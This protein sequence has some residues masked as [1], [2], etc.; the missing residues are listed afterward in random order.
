MCNSLLTCS[1]DIFVHSLVTI[2]PVFSSVKNIK[3]LRSYLGCSLHLNEQRLIECIETVG[4]CLDSEGPWPCHIQI[5]LCC[6]VSLPRVFH[7][8]LLRD[9]LHISHFGT[10]QNL[11]FL[12]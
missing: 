7:M 1:H 12:D 5:Y 4:M 10:R 8:A 11:R 3:R 2:R 6:I 9:H